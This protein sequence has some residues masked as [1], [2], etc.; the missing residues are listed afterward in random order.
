MEAKERLRACREKV[1]HKEQMIQLL[2]QIQH[3][4]STEMQ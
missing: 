2:R 3:D 1:E 4:K